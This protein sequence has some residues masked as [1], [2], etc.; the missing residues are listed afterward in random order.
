MFWSQ[1]V[2]TLTKANGSGALSKC[3][4]VYKISLHIFHLPRSCPAEVALKMGALQFSYV[5]P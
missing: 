1:R 5:K 2:G 4:C 3:P